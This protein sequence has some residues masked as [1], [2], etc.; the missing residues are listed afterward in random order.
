MSEA[1]VLDLDGS[2]EARGRGQAQAGRAEQVRAATVGRVAQAR[3]D[4]LIDAAAEDYLAAQRALH[5]QIDPEGL[6]ELDGI[7]AGFDL[8]PAE[9]FA[10]LHLG[11]LRDLKGGARLDDGCSAWAVA[12][13]PDGPLV[14]KN[15]DFSGTHL[16]I[17]TV[18]RHAGPDITTGAM[19]CLGSLGSPGA[20]SSGINAR[21]FAL[22][23][24]QVAVRHHRVGWLRY[25]LMTRLLARC[26]TVAEAL[27]LIRAHPHAGGGT[28]VMADATGAAAAVELGA[29]GPQVA[30]GPWVLRTNHYVSR[31]LAED[32]LLP[33]GDVIASNS[34]RRYDFLAAT[35][36]TRRWG[37][38]AAQALM[39]THPEQGAPVCQHGADDGT[40][41]I[42]SAVYSC[43]APGLLLCAG[44]PCRDAWRAHA[45]TG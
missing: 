29:S 11:T 18:A 2:A 30:R 14:V 24:T 31:A 12:E 21:G 16:G 3:A 44:S 7:A 13:G 35:L 17:Q 40:M 38:A 26:S 45:L 28:L 4:G 42:A 36:P 19:L 10:H 39:A 25:F 8:D 37:R 27:A 5:M 6:A 32:T 15:R 22:A 33:A 34:K 23:D 9:M 1:L 20:Y 41:T 43:R